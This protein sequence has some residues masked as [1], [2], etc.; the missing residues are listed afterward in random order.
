AVGDVMD[1]PDTLGS[2]HGGEPL[3][4]AGDVAFEGHHAVHCGHC[5]MAVDAGDEEKFVG[6]GCLKNLIASVHGLCHTMNHPPTRPINLSISMVF[7]FYFRKAPR[8]PALS[9]HAR[10]LRS[11]R[12]VT[13]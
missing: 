11:P 5:Q 9:V 6:D 7:G 12:F 8:C 1:A 10:P 13:P 3:R 4:D 2:L